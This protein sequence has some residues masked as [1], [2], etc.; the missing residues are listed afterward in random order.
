MRR[1]ERAITDPGQIEAL[2][3]QNQILR[4]A[5]YDR[6]E[7]YIVPVNYGYRYH[8]G[9]YTFYF[10]GAAAGRKYELSRCGP[11]VGF[12]LDSAYRLLEGPSPCQYSA[13]YASVIGTGRITLVEDPEE[14]QRGLDAIL[15]QAR[16]VRQEWSYP[17]ASLQKTAVF[18][19]EAE[20]LSCKAHNA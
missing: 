3:A 19:L 4:V 2:I 17:E 10:H 9:V 6:G 5:F 12:E 1:Q 11:R 14:K 8:N 18:R 15:S 7:L 13:A 20:T 16:G